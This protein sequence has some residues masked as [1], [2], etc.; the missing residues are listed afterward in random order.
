MPVELARQQSIPLAQAKQQ[1]QTKCAV[2]K[3]C[4]DWYC[5]D[6]WSKETDLDI[7]QLKVDN[8]TSI[9]MRSDVLPFLQALKQR[10]IQ[11]VLLTNAHPESLTIKIDKTGLDKHLDHIYSTH[12][13][14]HCNESLK[15]WQALLE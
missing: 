12:E 13:F 6:Y 1:I 4:L 2:V 3:G 5:I 15:L 10:N 11:R 7:C 8:A 9:A 14:G